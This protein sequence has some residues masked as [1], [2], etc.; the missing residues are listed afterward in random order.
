MQPYTEHFY[1]GKAW[2]DCREAYAKSQRYLCEDCLSKGILTTGEIVHHIKPITPENINDPNITLN[3]DNLKLVCRKCHADE[4]HQRKR[5][6]KVLDDGTV[7]TG[8]LSTDE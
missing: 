3:F 1:K 7:I 5:R 8:Y 4:H 6:Y 2:K